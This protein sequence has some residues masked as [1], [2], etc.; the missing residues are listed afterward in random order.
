MI[1]R[2]LRLTAIGV[3]T[4]VV[5]WF[6]LVASNTTQH[7]TQAQGTSGS[8]ANCHLYGQVSAALKIEEEKNDIEPAPPPFWVRP[9]VPLASLYNFIPIIFL[10]YLILRHKIHL[11]TQMR[12]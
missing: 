9:I 5:G 7:T 11:T 3:F 2:I 10:G 6:C 1:R 4:L 8:C 12:F